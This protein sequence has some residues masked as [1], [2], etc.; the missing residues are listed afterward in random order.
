[1]MV[2]CVKNT[3]NLITISYDRLV[4]SKHAFSEF[5]FLTLKST[6]HN[7]IKATDTNPIKNIKNES[8]GS[9]GALQW[10]S[11]KLVRTHTH[12]HTKLHYKYKIPQ[13]KIICIL[14]AWSIGFGT[15][16]KTHITHSDLMSISVFLSISQAPHNTMYILFLWIRIYVDRRRLRFSFRNNEEKKSVVDV[17]NGLSGKVHLPSVNDI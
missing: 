8:Y 5:L 6:E 7:I 11:L 2:D 4:F 15:R 16:T 10:S 12:T 1:M 17:P 3:P 13:P 9:V 14:T